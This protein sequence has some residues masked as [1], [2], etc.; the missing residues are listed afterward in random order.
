MPTISDDRVLPSWI[1]RLYPPGDRIRSK[2]LSLNWSLQWAA[3]T[4]SNL[5]ANPELRSRVLQIWVVVC[6]ISAPFEGQLSLFPLPRLQVGGRPDAVEERKA[7]EWYVGEQLKSG[8]S[9]DKQKLA[10]CKLVLL[11]I[12]DWKT[13]LNKVDLTRFGSVVFALCCS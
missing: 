7:D 10:Y 4:P 12:F 6:V 9:Y 1:K 5:T 11:S 13:L 2:K 3:N 8:F